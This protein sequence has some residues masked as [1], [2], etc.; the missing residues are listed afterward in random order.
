MIVE[1]I[2]QKTGLLGLKIKNIPVTTGNIVMYLT[3]REEAKRKTPVKL[4]G[5]ME[6]VMFKEQFVPVRFI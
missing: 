4:E 6:M 3:L 1:G 2:V 5:V